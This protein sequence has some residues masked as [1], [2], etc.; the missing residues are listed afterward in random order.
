MVHAYQGQRWGQQGEWENNR[1]RDDGR[2]DTNETGMDTGEIQVPTWMAQEDQAKVTPSR[3]WQRRKLGNE[4]PSGMQGRHVGEN[5]ADAGNHEGAARLQAAI[6]DATM[7]AVEVPA[8][9]TPNLAAIALENRKQA[10]WDSAQDQGVE[11]AM[12]TI[13][14][15]DA[16]S[17]EEWAAAYLDQL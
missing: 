17:L 12:E 11:V 10:V 15:M 14:K 4:D 5:D 8:P 3:A 16:E 13:A 1:S 7:A 6:S 9:P 2:V